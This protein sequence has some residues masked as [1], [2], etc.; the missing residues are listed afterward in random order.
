[1]AELSIPTWQN[2]STVFGNVVSSVTP[3]LPGDHAAPPA[4]EPPLHA[5]AIAAAENTIA[6]PRVEEL[7]ARPSM[8][9]AREAHRRQR[10]QRTVEGRGRR[11]ST[12]HDLS[13]VGVAAVQHAE[14]QIAHGGGVGFL[15]ADM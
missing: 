6:S 1:M 7:M 3:A 12:R 5:A 13:E 10:R 2:A 9:Q 11:G 8:G 15:H 4:P 14:V